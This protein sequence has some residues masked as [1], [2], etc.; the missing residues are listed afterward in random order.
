MF[1]SLEMPGQQ[2]QHESQP[3]IASNYLWS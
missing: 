2:Q 1:S 3:Q